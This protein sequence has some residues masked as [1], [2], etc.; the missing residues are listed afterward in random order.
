ML[1]LSPLTLVSVN[2]VVLLMLECVVLLLWVV[3][4]LLFDVV[5]VRVLGVDG[6]V[7]FVVV[8]LVFIMR[9]LLLRMLLFLE[10]GDVGVCVGGNVLVGGIAIGFGCWLP[11][12]CYC[13][14]LLCAL[15]LLWLMLSWL[16]WLCLFMMFLKIVFMCSAFGLRGCFRALRCC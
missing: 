11:C 8:E 3:L 5:V 15:L 2:C 1:I 12:S 4:L 16:L 9:L 14:V 10:V 13:C 7:A 6:G